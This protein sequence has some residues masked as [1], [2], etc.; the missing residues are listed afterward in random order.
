MYSCTIFGFVK[1]YLFSDFNV[2][3]VY[4][5]LMPVFGSSTIGNVK[6]KTLQTRIKTAT[7]MYI[8][9]NKNFI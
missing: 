5:I 9:D 3:H 4:F 7:I 1:F 8:G 6:D 2:Y